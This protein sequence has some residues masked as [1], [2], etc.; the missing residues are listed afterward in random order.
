MKAT[1]VIRRMDDLGRVCIP[2]AARKGL[3]INEG[4][5]F[6]MFIDLDNTAIYLKKYD[7]MDGINSSLDKLEEKAADLES[8]TAKKEANALLTDLRKLFE[9]AVEEF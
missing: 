4:D 1:G 5:A 6:E 9:K 2:R 7:P 8:L 3:G